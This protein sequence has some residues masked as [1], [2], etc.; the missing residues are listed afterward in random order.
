MSSTRISLPTENCFDKLFPCST[1]PSSIPTPTATAA[2]NV[3]NPIL[4][5]FNGELP[6]Y[7]WPIAKSVKG[8][9]CIT[10]PKGDYSSSSRL[11]NCCSKPL[12]SVTN[13][14]KP[15]D[16][17][18]PATCVSWCLVNATSALPPIPKDNEFPADDLFKCMNPDPADWKMENG[19]VY[20]DQDS[21]LLCDWVN[22]PKGKEEWQSK[23]DERLDLLRQA[24][25]T[26]SGEWAKPTDASSL[27]NSSSSDNSTTS[28]TE[29]WSSRLPFA[30]APLD[31]TGSVFAS[32]TRTAAA[33]SPTGAASRS[34]SAG[35]L[36]VVLP[37]VFSVMVLSL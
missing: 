34:I 31:A 15:D 27:T 7:Q 4:K 35:A 30:T 19:Y 32:T 33:G 23:Y 13:T 20:S 11:K 12:I 2:C 37:L 3:P 17:S 16:I 36:M 1:L 9:V 5:P 29:T 6:G 8:F 18:Y 22:D 26:M 28:T 10:P 24:D 21:E 25:E 14:T